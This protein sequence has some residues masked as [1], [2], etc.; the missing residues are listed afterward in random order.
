MYVEYQIFGLDKGNVTDFKISFF[1]HIMLK[2]RK[3]ETHV[4][5]L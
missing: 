4:I 2:Q 3:E 5:Y 1:N